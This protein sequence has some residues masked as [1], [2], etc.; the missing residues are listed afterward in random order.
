[1]KKNE[2]LICGIGQAGGQLVNELY[3]LD[4]RYVPLFVNSTMTDVED[5]E[6]FNLDNSFLFPSASGSGRDRQY[7]RKMTDSNIH[8]L[9]DKVLRFPMQS[10]VV[11]FTSADGGTGS[12]ISVGKLP[13]LLKR[14]G[15]TVN[16]VAVLPDYEKADKI[17]LEN[18]LEFL[19]ELKSLTDQ[20]IINNV[21]FIDNHTR[22]TYKEINE[23]AIKCIDNGYSI[24]GKSVEGNID[25]ADSKRVNN[26]SNY[27]LVLELNSNYESIDNAV[28]QAI[29][30]SVFA[31]PDS[32]A[33][34]YLGISL[35]SNFNIDLLKQKFT[36]YETA[37][38]TRNTEGRNTI[39]LSGM[40]YPNEIVEM[41]KIGLEEKIARKRNRKVSTLASVD[42]SMEKANKPEQEKEQVKVSYSAS[43]L[44]NLLDGLF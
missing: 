33:V 21:K 7:A 36:V 19:K 42:V 39:V 10:T 31:I 30:N 35:N 38:A 14:A 40:D 9:A 24:I 28:D 27:S 3:R 37:Y 29:K 41:I 17:S 4:K 11:I 34:D 1:M 16:M 8:S 32:F 5:L 2:I 13:I 12:G 18:T 20:G 15:K 43:E 6:A 22:K 26:A 25:D 44:N 23:E